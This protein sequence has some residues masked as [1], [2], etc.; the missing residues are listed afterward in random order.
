MYPYYYT[1]V[2]I[3]PP[4]YLSL[5]IIL[6]LSYTSSIIFS[7]FP[8][9][10]FNKFVIPSPSQS[11]SLSLSLSLSLSFLTLLLRIIPYFTNISFDLSP[12]FYLFFCPLISTLLLHFL[13]PFIFLLFSFLLPAPPIFFSINLL[14]SQLFHLYF[15]HIWYLSLPLSQKNKV[16]HV[17][18]EDKVV[19]VVIN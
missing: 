9:L 5:V 2:N 10:L 7:S 1:F 19:I 3:S 17:S 4:Y 11:T 13:Y 6:C 14:F 16:A 15:P 18:H 12:L 8:N